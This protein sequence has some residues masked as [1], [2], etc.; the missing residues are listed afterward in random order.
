MHVCDSSLFLIVKNMTVEK[1]SKVQNWC[2]A[3]IVVTMYS[4]FEKETTTACCYMGV[5]SSF[6]VYLLMQQLWDAWMLIRF[7]IFGQEMIRMSC[8]AFSTKNK[9][10][11][12]GR[13]GF[14]V[15]TIPDST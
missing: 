8:S 1:G 14:W 10:G 15:T 3:L 2:E 11:C 12:G 13:E 9:C 7:L 5:N 4:K 6:L